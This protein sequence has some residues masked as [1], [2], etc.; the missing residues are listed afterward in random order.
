MQRPN[1]I[2]LNDR[3]D[4]QRTGVRGPLRSYRYQNS[5]PQKLTAYFGERDR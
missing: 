5:P 4:M 2:E 3:F 1:E